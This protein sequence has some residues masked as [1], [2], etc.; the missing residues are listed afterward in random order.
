V[1]HRWGDQ[2]AALVRAIR[3][4]DSSTIE[5]AVLRVSRSRRWLAPLALCVSAMVLLF[6]GLRLVFSN[7]RLSA[8][9]VL[10][11][12]WIWLAMFDLKLHVLHGHS[13]RV[14]H[15]P[16]AWIAVAVVVGVT[17][18]AFQLNAMVAFAITDPVGPDLSR[19][20][21][22]ARAHRAAI[23]GWG[24]AVGLA[25]G[26]AT[27]IV[28]RYGPP[29]FA[30]SL[31][32][33]IGVMMVCYLTVPARIIGV[34]PVQSRRDRLVA[35]AISGTLG[36]V[37]STPAYVLGRVGLLML[38]SHVLFVFGLIFV[39]VG[40]TLQAGTTGALTAV[41]MSAK[42]LAGSRPTAV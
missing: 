42:L 7:W 3:E 31:S 38:G 17:A 29:W 28:T 4:G 9:Q 2:V 22:T 23:L 19:A 34:R 36:A 27:M 12:M 16:L 5:A 20:R 30:L 26:F 33:V 13:A 8:L 40:F 37:I 21:A 1:P 24:A 11:A 18:V 14:I 15:G 6:D 25:L 41:K 32:V 35:S 39:A 10:P